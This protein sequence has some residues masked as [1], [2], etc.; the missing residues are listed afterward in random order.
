MFTEFFVKGEQR[1]DDC[2]FRVKSARRV[3]FYI[4]YS[5]KC[6]PKDLVRGGMSL[7]VGAPPPPIGGYTYMK[8]HISKSNQPMIAINFFKVLPW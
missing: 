4:G 6:P 1:A 3:Y 7:G 5:E 2:E 8:F